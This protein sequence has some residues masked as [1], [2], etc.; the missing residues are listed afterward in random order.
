MKVD[1]TKSL[2]ILNMYERLK[3]GGIINKKQFA[4]E[5]NVSEKSVQRD[6]DELRAYLSENDAGV[7]IE[8]SYDRGGYRM[9][10]RENEYLTNEEIV[11]VAKVLFESNEMDNQELNT[12][13]DKL[14]I[15]APPSAK[16]AVRRVILTYCSGAE[17]IMD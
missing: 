9:T 1:N 5:F 2:R 6:I 11:E 3:R 7:S 17:S 14:L 15:W 4:N 16:E 10:G 13:I 12:F 8:Y